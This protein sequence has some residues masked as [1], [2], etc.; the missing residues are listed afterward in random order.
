MR[1]VNSMFFIV[2]RL[3]V[4]DSAAPSKRK[5]DIGECGGRRDH[6]E[7]GCEGGCES[8]CEGGCEGA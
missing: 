6:T 8:G 1:Y 3:F 7:A 2:F 4:L 5:E